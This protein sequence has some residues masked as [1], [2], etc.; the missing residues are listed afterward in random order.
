MVA[1]ERLIFMFKE[2]MIC[3]LDNNPIYFWNNYGGV[4]PNLVTTN[5]NIYELA[6]YVYAS[7]TRCDY[8]IT[9]SIFELNISSSDSIAQD[10]IKHYRIW[11]NQNNIDGLRDR[12]INYRKNIHTL[13]T[14]DRLEST[15]NILEQLD[16]NSN[17]AISNIQ[18]YL[19]NGFELDKFS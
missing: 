10:L 3:K 18:L 6:K 5:G 16:S 13:N 4:C 9:D 1:D 12:A 2:I 19:V 7:I 17:M 14:A 11:Q 15:A 8:E